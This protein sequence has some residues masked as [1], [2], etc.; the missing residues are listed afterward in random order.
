MR[1][2]ILLITALTMVLGITTSCGSADSEPE[3]VQ[4]E[5]TTTTTATSS[6]ELEQEEDEDYPEDT[7][8]YEIPDDDFE[9]DEPVI[10]S[11][12]EFNHDIIIDYTEDVDGITTILLQEDGIVIAKG[13]NNEGQLGN[14]QRLDQGIWENIAGLP[15]IKEIANHGMNFAISEDGDLYYWGRNHLSPEKYDTSEKFECFDFELGNGLIKTVDGNYYYMHN[16][17][18]K[19]GLSDRD[20]SKYKD[21]CN[22]VPVEIPDGT[23]SVYFYNDDWF[24]ENLDNT[25]TMWIINGTYIKYRDFNRE[26]E[27][28]RSEASNLNKISS[29]VIVH[30]KD[31]G[32][33]PINDGWYPRVYLTTDEGG[34][35]CIKE[36]LGGY[37]A[38]FVEETDNGGSGYVKYIGY[39]S[40]NSRYDKSSKSTYFDLFRN[41]TLKCHGANDWG[42][43]GDGTNME[44][45]DGSL[46]VPIESVHD[47]LQY[48][49]NIFAI[50][51]NNDIYAWGKNYY[52]TPQIIF[53]AS[54]FRLY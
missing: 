12:K 42:Q 27:Y 44:Y 11:Q 2:K 49:T 31:E 1:N 25:A 9:V 5:E 37:D 34:I 13:C 30:N 50:T 18:G 48:E 3:S 8:D 22:L 40:T 17:V 33:R 36:P 53:T 32:N 41:G 29:Y 4:T 14:G 26:N 10:L 39:S 51:D 28:Y 43:L 7:Y 52:N 16:C 21:Y 46:T 54:D 45:Y 24:H 6:A 15:T 38:S 20:Y 23:T 35:Y 47:V 19:G